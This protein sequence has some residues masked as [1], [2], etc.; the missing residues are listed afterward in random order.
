MRISE[1]VLSAGKEWAE[2]ALL[3]HLPMT[4]LQIRQVW[5]NETN[6]GAKMV[7]PVTKDNKPS[8]KE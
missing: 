1:Q 6:F 4:I 2:Y 8:L 3:K 7:R 5:I